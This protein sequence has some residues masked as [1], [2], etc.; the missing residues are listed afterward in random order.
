MVELPTFKD[1]RGSLT[2]WDTEV[3]FEV[4]RVFW[5]Y[6]VPVW[7]NRA[8]HGHK[9]CEQVIFAVSGSFMVNNEVLAHPAKGLYIP[10][11]H[12]ITLHNFSPGA[13]CLVM[14][15]THYDAT[16]VIE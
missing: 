10:I 1:E 16:E 11:G 15:S 8:G 13:V 2:V 9:E 4:K 6:D 3:P 7:Q 14:C 5:I 12:R